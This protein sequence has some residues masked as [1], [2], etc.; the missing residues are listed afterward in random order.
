VR[1]SFPAPGGWRRH[2]RSFLIAKMAV[3]GPDD[4]VE[5]FSEL[6]A[7]ESDWIRFVVQVALFAYNPASSRMC[8][9]PDLPGVTEA[10]VDDNRIQGALDCS[11]M[12]DRICDTCFTAREFAIEDELSAVPRTLTTP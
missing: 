7:R 11:A 12:S 10:C 3:M 5:T 8:Q 4:M 9:W 2:P 1:K 6:A